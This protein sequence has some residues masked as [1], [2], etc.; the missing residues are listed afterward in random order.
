M[1]DDQL[2]AAIRGMA[3]QDRISPELLGTLVSHLGSSVKPVMVTLILL[4]VEWKEAEDAV[5]ELIAG[6]GGR[7]HAPVQ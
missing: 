6:D 5:T 3:G 2:D 7:S 1:T 4:P